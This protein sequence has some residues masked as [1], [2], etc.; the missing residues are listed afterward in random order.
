MKDNGDKPMSE[1]VMYPAHIY[2]TCSESSV[3][4][5]GGYVFFYCGSSKEQ[6]SQAKQLATIHLRNEDLIESGT[7]VH[8]T[9]CTLEEFLYKKYREGLFD[10]EYSEESDY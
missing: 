8:R 10:G 6:Q 9:V 1:N 5:S 4:L 7:T 2:T 3:G